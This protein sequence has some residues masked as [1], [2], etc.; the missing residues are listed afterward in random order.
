MSTGPQ[1]AEIEGCPIWPK[2]E[3]KIVRPGWPNDD[4]STILPAVGLDEVG[5]E[6]GRPDTRRR[7]NGEAYGA[8]N[9]PRSEVKS[10]GGFAV[11]LI[12]C[13]LDGGHYEL[14]RLLRHDRVA[15]SPHE[16]H[17]AGNPISQR[18]NS[19]FNSTPFPV[20]AWNPLGIR[21]ETRD[22][23]A[24]RRPTP[25]SGPEFGWELETVGVGHKVQTVSPVRRPD[26]RSRKYRRPDGVVFTLQ[27]TRNL[28]EPPEPN[29]R[30]NLLPKE[31]WRL[32]LLD[33]AEQFR[34]QVPRVIESAARS[35]IAEGLAWAAAGP[36]WLVIGPSGETQRSAPSTD[37]R[38]EVALVESVKVVWR[39][40][41]D[42][43]LIDHPRR[44]QPFP[45]QLSQPRRRTPVV[46]VVVDAPHC[47]LLCPSVCT[48]GFP[49]GLWRPL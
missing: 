47:P 19:G 13:G 21:P 16:S 35:G 7:S 32:A 31:R 5:P 48:P 11:V 34:P 27:V 40:L 44:Y 38:K 12:R 24:S 14:G 6:T 46:L 29:R 22:H 28:V 49:P 10:G 25:H 26:A 36:D 4:R 8:R 2:S 18:T 15:R 3:P 33:E 30:R 20:W 39:H 42:A 43:P 9:E 37:P 1:A 45:H 17:V 41:L 23:A